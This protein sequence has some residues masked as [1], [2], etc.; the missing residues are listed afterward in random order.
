MFCPACTSDSCWVVPNLHQQLLWVQHIVQ[1]DKCLF[2]NLL[3]F[4]NVLVLL[5]K[6]LKNGLKRKE[7]E[8]AGSMKNEVPTCLLYLL[9]PFLFMVRVT[10]PSSVVVTC[11]IRLVITDQICAHSL[12][13]A[14]PLQWVNKWILIYLLYVLA[15]ERAIKKC[16][17]DDFSNCPASTQVPKKDFPK[18]LA[19]DILS[20]FKKACLILI[21]R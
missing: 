18:C 1:H 19:T 11:H 15:S 13:P 2:P 5:L 7:K 17:V 10:H 12:G 14:I 16:C 9:K 8:K 21:A 20:I 3:I 6:N 4:F